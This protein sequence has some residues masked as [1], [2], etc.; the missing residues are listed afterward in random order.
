MTFLEVAERV[1]KR[2][3]Y[4]LHYK[5]MWEIAK[6]LGLD[7]EVGSEGK[8]PAVTMRA[9]IYVDMRDKS[10]TKFYI[11][12]KRPTKFWLKSRRNEII[13]DENE[14]EIKIES[15]A[16]K[17]DSKHS[18]KFHERN[19]HP[20]LVY[21]LDKDESFKLKCKTIFHEKCAR[22]EQGR[23]KWNYP[24]IVGVKFP[25]ERNKETLNL[26]ANIKQGEYKL[27]SFELKKSIEFGNLKEFYFQ[28]VSNSSWANEGYLVVF[29]RIDKEVRDELKRLNA[30]FGIGVI[31]LDS[32]IWASEV[33]LPALQRNLDIETLDMLVEESPDFR[34]FV[35]DINGHIK[36]KMDGIKVKDEFDKVEGDIEKYLKEKHIDEQ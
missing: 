8:T 31:Q 17:N 15:K 25:F 12:S 27:Y 9:Q 22:K 34:D 5:E 4:P 2:A 14:L 6:N 21:F 35:N 24:D 3:K 10:D 16:P 32:D 30:S 29:E 26:L 20:L 13:G 11:A 23:A 36:G 33:I 28:A 19:L 18:A 1:L 7:K